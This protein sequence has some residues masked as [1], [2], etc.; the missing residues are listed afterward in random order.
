MCRLRFVPD[1]TCTLFHLIV[2]KYTFIFKSNGL[3]KPEKIVILFWCR[4]D[5]KGTG[6]TEI[7]IFNGLEK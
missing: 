5:E 2:L 4:Q 6:G 1:G 7:H 3:C